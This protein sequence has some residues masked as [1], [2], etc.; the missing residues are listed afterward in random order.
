MSEHM[1]EL[2]GKMS[3]TDE[4]QKAFEEAAKPLMKFL[5][6]RCN[7]HTSVMVTSVNAELLSGEAVFESFDFLVD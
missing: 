4:K 1:K 5:A 6:E 2:E 7:P 3:M